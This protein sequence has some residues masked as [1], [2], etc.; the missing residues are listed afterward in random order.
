M[1]IT[2]ERTAPGT[3]MTA[4]AIFGYVKCG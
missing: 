3:G 4:A 2:S 1:Y